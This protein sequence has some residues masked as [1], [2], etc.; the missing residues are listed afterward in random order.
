MR[1]RKPPIKQRRGRLQNVRLLVTSQL[2]GDYFNLAKLDSEIADSYSHVRLFKKGWTG[3]FAA[4]WGVALVGCRAE[5]T[6]LIPRARSRP[7]TAATQ[8]F[9]DAILCWSATRAGFHRLRCAS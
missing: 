8:A 1:R 3:E 5:E 4:Q 7:A 9:E 2:A 6:L